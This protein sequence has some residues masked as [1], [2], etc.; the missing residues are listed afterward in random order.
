ELVDKRD[1]RTLWQ[2]RYND[3]FGQDPVPRVVKVLLVRFMVGD[4]EVQMAFH[5]NAPVLLGLRWLLSGEA[6]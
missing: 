2:G 6:H 4:E 5:E 3:V 1:R